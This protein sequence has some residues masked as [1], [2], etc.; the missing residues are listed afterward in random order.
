MGWTK[1]QFALQA[2]EEIGYADY[3]Y[4][5]QP[6]QLVTAVQKMDAMVAAWQ[7]IGLNFAY[8]MPWSPQN[9]NID[10]DTGVPMAANEAIYFNLGIR[11]APSVGKV[12]SNEFKATAQ[13]ALGAL[14]NWA[15]RPIPQMVM[16]GRM[17]IGAGN[18]YWNA[19]SYPF[20][21]S[22]RYNVSQGLGP[23]PFIAPTIG[24]S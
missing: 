19:I 5:L 3:V 2:F 20:Y 18:K 10:Q 11:I 16:P 21:G 22:Y 12:L 24:E 23:T 6:E 1:R 17:P 14:F 8:P 15:G 4:G 7:Q 13:G 9:T